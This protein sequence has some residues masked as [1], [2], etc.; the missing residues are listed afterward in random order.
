MGG[1]YIP[2]SGLGMINMLGHELVTEV[3]VGTRVVAYWR[4]GMGNLCEV[5]IDEVDAIGIKWQGRKIG[6]VYG[7]RKVEEG[8][9]RYE[10][11]VKQM[12]NALR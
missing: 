5:I 4:Q 10:E 8:N 12:A 6:E 7:G 2:K 9:R 3:K 1:C 11:W